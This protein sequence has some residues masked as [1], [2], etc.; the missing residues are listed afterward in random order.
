[1]YDLNDP[2]IRTLLIGALV[3]LPFKIVGLW[4][5]AQ[6]NQK[7]WFG[8]MLLINSIGL[9]ELVYLFYF[10]KRSQDTKS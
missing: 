8:A 4:K 3:S 10:S 7:G 6:N 1:M 9:L 2:L 5:S